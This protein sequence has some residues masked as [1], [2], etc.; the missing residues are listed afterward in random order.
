MKILMLIWAFY[1]KYPL[2][3]IINILMLTSV[4]FIQVVSTLLIAPVIDVFISPE[5]KDVSSIT[6]RLFNLFNLFGISVTK[7]NILILFFLFNT[8]LSVSIIVTNWIIVKAQYAMVKSLAVETFSAFFNARWHF[9]NTQRYGSILNT[10]TREI[11]GVRSAFVSVGSMLSE[12]IRA[13]FFIAVPIYISWKITLIAVVLGCFF[14]LPF[15]LFNRASYRLGKGS[16]VSSNKVMELIHESLGA[17]K[18][19]L[20]YGNHKKYIRRFNEIFSERCNFEVKSDVLQKAL[21]KIFEPF[22]WMVIIIT[23]YISSEY[24]KLTIAEM[25]VIGY[26]FLRLLPMIGGFTSIKHSIVSFYPSYEQV[27]YMNR[28]ACENIQKTGGF[29]FNRIDDSFEYKGVSFSY[30]GHNPVLNDINMTIKKGEMT[31]IVGE[32]GSGK[33]TLIDLLIGFYEPDKGVIYVDKKP[34]QEFDIYSFRRQIGYVPQDT[35]LFNDTV[36]NNLLWSNEKATEMEIVEACKLANA[37]EFIMELSDG[38]DTVV[39][40]RGVRLSGGERQRIALAR[41]LLNKP[42]LLILDEATSALDS[43][44]EL[45]IKSAI[46]NIAH[47]TTLVVIAH[48]LSTIVNADIIY[49]LQKGRI[50]EQGKYDSLISL[51]GAFRR[52]AEIQRVVH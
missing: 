47:K 8:L 11:D 48:R 40:E 3:F 44:S 17:V 16:T 52:T 51:D 13:I 31:A 24:S 29:I 46:E 35:V 12:F 5:F 49:V 6:Q 37:R 10:L 38:Y 26:A 7:I 1:K 28:L 2:F 20:G 50:I 22:G 4:C 21:P 25:G 39:G 23:M 32:S 14:V 45:L 43:R 18:V 41:A 27:A 9:F 34:L 19:I 42:E 36:K 30:P 33:S 15:M